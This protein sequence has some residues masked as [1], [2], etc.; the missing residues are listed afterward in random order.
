MK[1][2]VHLTGSPS[3]ETK[4][5]LVDLLAPSK[6]A[7]SSR[8]CSGS[9]TAV[10]SFSDLYALEANDHRAASVRHYTGALR[11]EGVDDGQDEEERGSESGGLCG[12]GKRF[13][14]SGA[15]ASLSQGSPVF[16]RGA[17]RRSSRGSDGGD[18]E[19]LEVCI[20]LHYPWGALLAIF[21]KL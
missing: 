10:P 16:G 4:Q 5:R 13:K 9:R 20:V 3:A 8:L 21:V 19:H 11:D 14:S 7:A 18:A 6:S 1:S 2:S 17:P 15:E 12:E